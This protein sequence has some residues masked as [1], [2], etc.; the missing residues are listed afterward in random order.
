MASAIAAGL[1]A[2]HGLAPWRRSTRWSDLTVICLRLPRWPSA[3]FG[4]LGFGRGLVVLRDRVRLLPLDVLEAVLQAG[5][6]D[7]ED[8]VSVDRQRLV[9]IQREITAEL[10]QSGPD[11]VGFA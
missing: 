4:G 10:Q 7:Q 9:V 5:Q 1:L 2:I 8:V 11:G 6:F 3:G